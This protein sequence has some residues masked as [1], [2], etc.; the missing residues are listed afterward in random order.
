MRDGITFSIATLVLSVMPWNL[1]A[2]V[3]PQR[4][5]REGGPEPADKIRWNSAPGGSVTPELRR[6]GLCDSCC[7]AWHRHRGERHS[8]PVLTD[9]PT[10]IGFSAL[11]SIQRVQSICVSPVSI[12]VRLLQTCIWDVTSREMRAECFIQMGEMGKAISDL[13]AASKLKNDNTQAFYKLSTI[14]Y[15]LGDHEMSLR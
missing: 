6:Q 11:S 14:Y 5:R 12:I 13:K 9:F 3:Q 15:N 8:L 1:L 2:E 4:Q 7:T 10:S